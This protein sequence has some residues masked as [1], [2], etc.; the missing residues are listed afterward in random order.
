[1]LLNK[2]Q[3]AQITTVFKYW[4]EIKSL[5]KNKIKDLGVGD[6]NDGD[7]LIFCRYF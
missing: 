2:L 6:N 4:L 5:N 1:M 3:W 7:L